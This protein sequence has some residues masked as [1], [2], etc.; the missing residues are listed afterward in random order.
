M[1]EIATLFQG[2]VD[3]L[4]IYIREAHP[5]GGWEAP[6]QPHNV[7]QAATTQERLAAAMAFFE[8]EKVVGQTAV[9]GIDNHTY[10]LYSAFPDRILV[11]NA[12]KRLI[13]V[14]GSGPINFQPSELQSF[15]AK[16][17]KK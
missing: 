4:T 2:D 12:E 7:E 3:W 1:S 15:L 17:L 14:Q 16:L 10:R 13:H 9:D 6:D 8:K 11:M 5:L